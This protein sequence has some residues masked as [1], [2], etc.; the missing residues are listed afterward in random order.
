MSYTPAAGNALNFQFPA[1]AYSPPQGSAVDLNF[2][3]LLDAEI[4]CSGGIS[5][6]GSFDIRHGVSVGASGGV[7]PL[8]AAL[9]LTDAPGVA[10]GPIKLGGEAV[11]YRGTSLSCNGR[12]TPSGEAFVV[13]ALN[14]HCVGGVRVNGTAEIVRGVRVSANKRI[15]LTGGVNINAG[16]ALVVAGALPAL[17]GGKTFLHGITLRASGS[18]GIRGKAVFSHIGSHTLIAEGSI[19]LGG[20]V[21]A[22]VKK[23]A[24]QHSLSVFTRTTERIE[25]IHHGL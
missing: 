8:L 14:V 25:V 9:F 2:G 15:N 3:A 22:V 12:I 10:A 17:R 11:F 21:S 20:A 13:A 5:T 7:A 24:P 1:R 4:S 16:R 18:P 19:D 6:T 23:E